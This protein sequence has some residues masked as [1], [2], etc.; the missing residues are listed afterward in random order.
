M[1]DALSRLT[2]A[3]ARIGEELRA[4]RK[5][6]RP[7]KPSGPRPSGPNAN[8]GC[9]TGAGG[10]GAG[11]S[12][13]KEDGRPNAPT[14]PVMRPVN[15]KADM[16][17]AKAMKEKAAKKQAAK[18]AADKARAEAYR[19]IKEAKAAAKSKQKRIEKL[20]KAAAERKA[21]KGERDAAEMKA[22][23]EAAAAK[24]AAMLQKIRV[25]K[26]NERIK[27]V[28]RPANPF[29]GSADQSVTIRPGETQ[30]DFLRRKHQKDLDTYHLEASKIETAYEKQL[31]DAFKEKSQAEMLYRATGSQPMLDKFS[32]A[33]KTIE[34]L[35]SKRDSELHDLAGQFTVAHA[36]ALA[37]LQ[38]LRSSSSVFSGNAPFTAKAAAEAAKNHVAHA[39]NWLSRVAAKKHEQRLLSATVIFR[40]GGGGSHNAMNGMNEA[41]IGVDGSSAS[42]RKTVVH[43]YGHAIE[44]ASSKTLNDLAEDYKSRAS[45]F[46]ES[47]KGSSVKGIPHAKNYEAVYRPGE[48]A[49]DYDID[50]PSYLGYARRYSDASFKESLIAVYANHPDRARIDKGT[51]VFSTGIEAL[52]KEPSAF[53]KRARHGFDITL[54]ILAGLM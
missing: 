2:R 49:E 44:S 53:R 22:A 42:I 10:F 20:R 47:N 4:R 52:Y 5:K 9:G 23:A 7:Q 33:Q 14:S 38:K 35:Q 32:A 43:E 28:E 48:L 34:E 31:A 41:T 40:P 16:A 50:A 54:L 13:A 21:E 3:I 45:M 27:I 19:P 15:A 11:N 8:K 39:W 36:G 29:S 24:R 12:C 26:A 17:K 6:K 18:I 25:K 37:D 1:D 46:L 51:E 30:A